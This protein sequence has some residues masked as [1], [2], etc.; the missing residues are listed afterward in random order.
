MPSNDFPFL[1]IWDGSTLS[2][3]FLM[4]DLHPG[5]LYPRSTSHC[6][7]ASSP[8]YEWARMKP[9]INDKIWANVH[10]QIVK[11]NLKMIYMAT[12]WRQHEYGLLSF[13]NNEFPN[14]MMGKYS[15]QW[16]EYIVNGNMSMGINET[17]KNKFC[18]SQIYSLLKKWQNRAWCWLLTCPDFV[19]SFSIDIIISIMAHKILNDVVGHKWMINI[20]SSLFQFLIQYMHWNDMNPQSM[21]DLQFRIGQN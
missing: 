15:N 20:Q 10:G 8:Q 4:P 12:K 11:Y 16:Y 2:P 6:P 5:Q 17:K 1:N 13:F 21:D 7:L 3:A 19:L 14:M 9:Q 18:F